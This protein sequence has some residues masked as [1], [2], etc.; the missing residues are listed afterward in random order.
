[1]KIVFTNLLE[2]PNGWDWDANKMLCGA[3]FQA[4]NSIKF[5]LDNL[6]AGFWNRKNILGWELAGGS[7]CW[8]RLVMFLVVKLGTTDHNDRMQ[9]VSSTQMH[10]MGEGGR[11][12][13]EGNG[14]GGRGCKHSNSWQMSSHQVLHTRNP[15]KIQTWPSLGQIR[16]LTMFPTRTVRSNSDSVVSHKICNRNPLEMY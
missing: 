8:K 4:K 7:F 12:G 11:M 13:R 3:I 5:L 6:L 2:T 1:M 14:D 16:V 10:A 9:S 15:N